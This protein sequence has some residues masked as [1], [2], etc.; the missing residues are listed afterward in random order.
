M[1]GI[2]VYG[3]LNELVGKVFFKFKFIWLFKIIE[4]EKIG[5]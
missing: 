1:I 5:Y 2:I 4:R 3:I